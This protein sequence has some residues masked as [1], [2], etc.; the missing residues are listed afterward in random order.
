MTDFITKSK[1]SVQI[2]SYPNEYIASVTLQ[3]ETP[4]ALNVAQELRKFF[5][6]NNFSI[7]IYTKEAKNGNKKRDC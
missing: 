6:D 2:S 4:E 5:I 1:T 3:K 7:S